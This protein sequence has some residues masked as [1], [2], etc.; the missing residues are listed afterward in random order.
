M[1]LRYETV[2]QRYNTYLLG[3]HLLTLPGWRP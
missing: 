2:D 3:H 1:V